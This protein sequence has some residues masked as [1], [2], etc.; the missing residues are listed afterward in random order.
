MRISSHNKNIF[1]NKHMLMKK[2][3][4]RDKIREGGGSAV[5]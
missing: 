1:F 2:A 4:I 5:E 3:K